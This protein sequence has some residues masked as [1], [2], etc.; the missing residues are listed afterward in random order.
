MKFSIWSIFWKSAVSHRNLRLKASVL[1]E[2]RAQRSRKSSLYT[3][4]TAVIHFYYWFPF[5][6]RGRESETDFHLLVLS[7]HV[8]YSQGR[9]RL[10]HAGCSSG[11]W[12]FSYHVPPRRVWTSSSVGVARTR[13]RH[14]EVGCGCPSGNWNHCPSACIRHVLL[15]SGQ[16]EIVKGLVAF[17]VRESYF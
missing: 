5:Y 3:N 16:G 15:F 2:D 17:G 12:L 6:L 1:E 7:T 10:T 9:G 8:H 13:T 11:K 4:S 14:S